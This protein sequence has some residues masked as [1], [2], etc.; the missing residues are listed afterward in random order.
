M[1]LDGCERKFVLLVTFYY[2]ETLKTSGIKRCTRKT[3]MPCPHLL[4]SQL[5]KDDYVLRPS[6]TTKTPVHVLRIMPPLLYPLTLRCS[7][8]LALSPYHSRTSIL[9][10]QFAFGNRT[11]A[12]TNL[13]QRHLGKQWLP[14]DFSVL[15]YLSFCSA[16]AILGVSWDRLGWA[17]RA[18]SDAL[19]V[20][21]SMQHRLWIS[22]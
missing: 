2:A 8:Q 14:G 20:F 11:L 9:S 1:L 13:I 3:A 22:S 18:G 7:T 16:A 12:P 15:S 19:V 17:G 21:I 5:G 10:Y 4:S 6:F